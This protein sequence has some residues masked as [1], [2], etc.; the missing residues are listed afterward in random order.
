M[1]NN[2]PQELSN[3]D[4]VRDFFV[5]FKQYIPPADGKPSLEEEDISAE[6]LKLKL[7]LIAEEFFELVEA[8][9]NAQASEHM[10]S[11]W[12]EVYDLDMDQPRNLDI[13][14]AADATGDLRY[15]I[16]GFDIEANI[17]SHKIFN[18]IHLS[19]LSKLDRNGNPI[20]SDGTDGNKVGKILKGEDFFDPDLKSVLNDEVP[21]RTPRL[22]KL[23]KKDA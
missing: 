5:R 17:P 13:V 15:V 20:L 14:E 11:A 4:K 1:S 23:A 3:Y 10:E 21:D 2:K 18:E 12:K 8:V 19:N 7:D 16:E 9:Y 6:R 22:I